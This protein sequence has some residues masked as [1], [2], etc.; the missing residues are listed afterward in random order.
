MA[1]IL[2]A[3]CLR[4][5]NIAYRLRQLLGK[6]DQHLTFQARPA[7]EGLRVA[8][9]LLNTSREALRRGRRLTPR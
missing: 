5:A 6:V 3:V 2:R 8:T 9:Y 4:T 7:F 1:Y